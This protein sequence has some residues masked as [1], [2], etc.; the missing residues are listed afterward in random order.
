MVLLKNEF[1]LLP[2]KDAG[3]KIALIGP[4]AEERQSLMGCWC[5]DG[6]AQD[7]ETLHEALQRNLPNNELSVT[8]G[9]SINGNETDFSEAINAALQADVVILAV[10]EADTM[11]VLYFTLLGFYTLSLL[12]RRQAQIAS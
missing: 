7:V 10:G 5:F 12:K 6:Q 4:L 1:S 8:P 11:V 9:C 2:L 3:K